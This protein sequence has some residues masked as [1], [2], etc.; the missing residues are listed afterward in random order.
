MILAGGEARRLGGADKPA[1]AVGGRPLL[2]WVA[3]AAAGARRL[4]VVGP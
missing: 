4:V 3:E 1:A 2:A